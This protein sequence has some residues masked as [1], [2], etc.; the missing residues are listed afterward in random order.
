MESI[1]QEERKN[2]N[3]ANEN[4]LQHLSKMSEIRRKV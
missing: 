3:V 2:S 1:A 4:S